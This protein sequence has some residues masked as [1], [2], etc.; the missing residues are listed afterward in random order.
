MPGMAVMTTSAP[1]NA[2]TVR[3]L[4][5][6]LT[7]VIG[8]TAALA[9]GLDATTWVCAEAMVGAATRLK[10]AARSETLYIVI[11]MIDGDNT[12]AVARP[13]KEPLR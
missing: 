7:T 5:V 8:A 11:S 12:Q 1:E 10:A 9:A 13:L 2:G 6:M 4:K 3:S